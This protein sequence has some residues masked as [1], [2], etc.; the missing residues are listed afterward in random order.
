MKLPEPDQIGQV[1][2]LDGMTGVVALRPLAEASALPDSRVF[3]DALAREWGD[4]APVELEPGVPAWLVLGQRLVYEVMRG[5]HVFV[6]DPRRWNGHARGGPPPGSGLAAILA[7]HRRRAANHTDGVLHERLRAPLD[8][9]FARLAASEGSTAARV[10]TVCGLLVDR[11]VHR[12]EARRPEGTGEA[13]LMAEYASALGYLVVGDLVGLDPEDGHRLHDLTRRLVAGDAGAVE[14]AD[15]TLAR[16]VAARRARP[17]RDLA[18]ELVAHPGL[19]D[20][21]EVV[22]SL[23]AVACAGYLTLPAWV[24]QTLLLALTDARFAARLHGG[25][26]DLELAVPA[27]DLRWTGGPWIRQ[28]DRLPVTFRPV[29]SAAHGRLRT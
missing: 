3:Y 6:T 22:H 27:S 18:G 19:R 23:L 14:E 17:R 13:D 24:G 11:F 12:A 9:A 10:R 1:L 29:V 25:R 7:P 26:L 15:R 8:D 28:P 16:A 4:V 21:V 20:D 2:R 5:D